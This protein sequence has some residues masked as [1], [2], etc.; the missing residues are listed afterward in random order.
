MKQEQEYTATAKIDSR[1]EIERKM[2]IARLEDYQVIRTSDK[3][4]TDYFVYRQKVVD[5]YF[6]GSYNTN[7]TKELLMDMFIRVNDLIKEILGL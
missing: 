1:I 7:E 6:N 3:K 5:R 2:N 4:L